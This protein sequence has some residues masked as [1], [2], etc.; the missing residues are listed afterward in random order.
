[1][2]IKGINLSCIFVSN[3]IQ[4]GLNNYL[5]AGKKYGLV[6]DDAKIFYNEALNSVFQ[7]KQMQNVYREDLLKLTNQFH[8]TANKEE[9]I[10]K[11]YAYLGEM[12]CYWFLGEYNLVKSIQNTV[13][14]TTY[15]RS[16]W[17]ENKKEILSIGGGALAGLAALL[18]GGVSVPICGAIAVM[19]SRTLQSCIS[20]SSEMENIFNNFKSEI[21]SIKFNI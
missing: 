21:I 1:M 12:M 4:E 7:L 18:T 5:E 15:S 6:T 11:L 17:E 16:W 3:S 19:G 20:S 13:A 14:I 10:F 9:C 8:I 2:Q